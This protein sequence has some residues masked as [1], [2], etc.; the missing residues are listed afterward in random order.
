MFLGPK[1]IATFRL[2]FTLSG[3]SESP[4]R[5]AGRDAACHAPNQEFFGT[6]EIFFRSIPLADRFLSQRRVD[7]R[8]KFEIR[9]NIRPV[10]EKARFLER[11]IMSRSDVT[12][13]CHARMSRWMSRSRAWIFGSGPIFSDFKNSFTNRFLSKTEEYFVISWKISLF[14]A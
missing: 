4:V 5:T 10:H 13:R 1:I 9:K 6:R 7:W 8:K 2:P 11:D 12:L 3:W 14:E